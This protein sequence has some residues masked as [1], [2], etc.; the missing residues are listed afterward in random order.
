MLRRAAA[1][2]LLRGLKRRC[3]SGGT[4]KLSVGSD[5]PPV[6]ELELQGDHVEVVLAYLLERGFPSKRSGG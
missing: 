1:A 3:G 4:L 5:G 2:E 6:Q